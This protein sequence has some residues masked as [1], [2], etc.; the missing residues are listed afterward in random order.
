MVDQ[1]KGV[2]RDTAVIRETLA[3]VRRQHDEAIERLS[4]EKDALKRQV[5]E[6]TADLGRL[7][8]IAGEDNPRLV[9]TQERIQHA[10][11]RLTEIKDELVSL[12]GGAIDEAEIKSTLRSFDQL[13]DCLLPKEQSRIIELLVEQVTYDG[14]AGKLSITYRPI[15]FRTLTTEFA[16][17]TEEAA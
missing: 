10:E 13:W 6:D 11:C 15:G 8:A 17:R 12:S 4:D 1:I 7:A 16:N 9:E 14:D 2:G 3:Q 5:V